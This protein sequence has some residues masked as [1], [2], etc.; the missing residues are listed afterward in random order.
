[1]TIWVLGLV[2]SSVFALATARRRRAD[3]NLSP[4]ETISTLLAT[5]SRNRPKQANAALEA[6]SAILR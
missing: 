2:L 4:P 3:V 1:M 6:A 5:L